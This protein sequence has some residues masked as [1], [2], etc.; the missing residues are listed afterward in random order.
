MEALGLPSLLTQLKYV[1]LYYI[2]TKLDLTRT[3]KSYE[4]LRRVE[5]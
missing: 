5:C 2:M 4:T 3:F 1:Y